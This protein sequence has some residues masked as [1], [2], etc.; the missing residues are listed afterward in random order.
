MGKYPITKLI[1]IMN[2]TEQI[3]SITTL[4][5]DIGGVLLTNG[6]GHESRYLAADKYGIDIAEMEDRHSLAFDTYEMNKMSFDEYLDLCIFFEPRNFSKDEFKAFMFQQSKDLPGH[7]DFFTALKNEYRLK[8]IAVSNEGRELNEYRIQ[9][10]QLDKL[11][12]AYISSCYVHLHKPDKQMLQMACDISHTKKEQALYIDD[13]LALIDVAK[14]FGIS[15]HQ[16]TSLENV[17]NFL[18]TCTF[19]NTSKNNYNVRTI[20]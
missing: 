3:R 12:D 7:I 13:R 1:E 19:N 4:F 10:F 6:W 14:E 16:F 2:T 8:V 20:V 18:N 15:A 17:K 11:F 5:L 9:Q